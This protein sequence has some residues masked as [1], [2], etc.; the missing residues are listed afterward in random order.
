MRTR[1]WGS[2]E[3]QDPETLA[4]GPWSCSGRGAEGRLQVS[5]EKG[6]I[7]HGILPVFS[8]VA[9]VN[10]LCNMNQVVS[11]SPSALYSNTS[12]VTRLD[13]SACGVG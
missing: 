12:C 6:C 11:A 3:A 7:V 5:C 4:L 10:P 8:V 1:N 13:P 2:S 9:D